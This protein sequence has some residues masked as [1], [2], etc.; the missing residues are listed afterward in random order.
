MLDF[1]P[2]ILKNAIKNVNINDVYE[3]RL[4]VNQP[5]KINYKGDY[6]YLGNYGVTTQ[7][8][9]ALVCTRQDIED[10]VFKAGNCSVYAVEEQ[11]KRGFITAK[12]GERIGLAGEYV[13][14]NGKPL[15]IRN[16]T[17]LCIRIPHKVEGCGAKIYAACLKDSLK[18][19]L[20]CSPPGLGKTTILR[21]L[22]RQISTYHKCNLLICDERGEICARDAEENV[23]VLRFCQKE[24]AFEAGIRA[25][26]PD[27]IV[28]DEL[29]PH[30]L[31]AIER[32]VH[33]GITVLASAHIFNF[34]DVSPQ[35]LRLFSRFV[36]LNEKKIGEIAY[37]YN[38]KG[39]VIGI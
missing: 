10:C 36:I 20:I 30:D 2:Q 18:N 6:C 11:I 32:A 35:F 37:V 24:T 22:A 29:S 9:N 8:N 21:D 39:E 31:G 12:N 4:R 34:K 3:L 38:A 7:K 26:R 15:T 13:L 25:M 5:I 1:L 17:S 16:F 33:A 14:E 19:I 23:D 28:T 27:V